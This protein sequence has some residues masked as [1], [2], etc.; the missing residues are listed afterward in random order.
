MEVPKASHLESILKIRRGSLRSPAVLAQAARQNSLSA[1]RA[2]KE[3]NNSFLNKSPSNLKI[4][5]KKNSTRI[6]M[7]LS[8]LPSG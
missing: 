1:T 7:M 6:P 5:L 4:F 3:E 2:S 8:T